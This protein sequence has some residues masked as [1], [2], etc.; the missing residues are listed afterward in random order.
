[1]NSE[2]RP[3]L[4]ALVQAS[5]AYATLTA[6]RAHEIGEE[7][8]AQMA[9]KL[10]LLGAIGLLAVCLA[11]GAA[12][13]VTRK[14]RRSLGHA[15][16]VAQAVANG[17]LT[18]DIHDGGHDEVAALMR[19]LK[20]MTVQLETL[21]MRARDTSEHV[22]HGAS[23]VA[24]GSMDLS[25]RTERQASALQ[26]TA[27][28]MEQMTASVKQNADNAHR[29]AQLSTDAA[30]AAQRGGAVVADV[31]STMHGKIGRAHV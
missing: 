17:D 19:A 9:Q 21:I 2:C 28:S 10:R 13:F 4:A 14:V 23:E 6:Q 30:S 16:A 29:A 8:A 5:N 24:L 12:W 26:E 20:A 22:N 7:A 18:V 27:A 25:Q 11:A 1:M 3:L 15:V 31:V